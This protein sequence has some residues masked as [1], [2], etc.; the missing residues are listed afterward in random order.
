M[1]YNR[2]YNFISPITGKI[3]D[4]IQL[5]FIHAGSIWTGIL[6]NNGHE[7]AAPFNLNDLFIEN[8]PSL[9]KLVIA[10]PDEPI[11]E[12]K[13]VK[14]AQANLNN[15]YVSGLEYLLLRGKSDNSLPTNAQNLF[16]VYNSNPLDPNILKITPNIT[17]PNIVDVS[18][19]SIGVD[20]LTLAQLEEAEIVIA[21]SIAISIT[22]AVLGEST[23]DPAKPGNKTIDLK[24]RGVPD[25]LYVGD[26]KTG[27]LVNSEGK[28]NVLVGLEIM[29]YPEGSSMLAPEDNVALGKLTMSVLGVGVGGP[30]KRNVAVGNNALGIVAGDDNVAIGYKTMMES[31]LASSCV[32]VGS[33]ALSQFGS[34]NHF[35]PSSWIYPG[36]NNVAM[37]RNAMRT[38]IAGS[39]NVAIGAGALEYAGNKS[40]PLPLPPSGYIDGSVAIG[41]E[42]LQ[43]LAAEQGVIVTDGSVAIG[44][45][46]LSWYSPLTSS[47]LGKPNIAIGYGSMKL[48]RSGSSNIAIGYRTLFYL[49]TDNLNPLTAENRHIAIGDS[50][51]LNFGSAHFYE[52]QHPNLAIGSEALLETRNRGNFAIGDS[53]LK[54]NNT[55]EFNMGVGIYSDVT[56]DDLINAT[57]IGVNAKVGKSHSLILGGEDEGGM[58]SKFPRLY[59]PNIGLGT[60]TPHYTIDVNNTGSEQCSA[61][62]LRETNNTPSSADNAAILYRKN[63]FLNIDNPIKSM[64]PYFFGKYIKIPVGDTDERPSN[65]EVGMLRYNIEI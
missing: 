59:Y 25:N 55:G 7:F 43:G 44:H 12:K 11:Q 1:K 16:S 20:Y 56:Q 46:A 64:N 9:L 51:L 39:D 49:N 65:S 27:S 15:D 3:A 18:I 35:S 28:G 32:A 6:D 2:L 26:S 4:Y 61:I 50:A 23:T 47:P 54:T 22:G 62:A 42:A 53:S 60:R 38:L 45:Q 29:N 41:F 5:P 33:E 63:G 19:A 34:I 14:F 8:N 24:L 31:I 52:Y 30:P 57:A 21:Q 17:N 58:F 13:Y 36:N 48:C 37:G 40:L 10:N